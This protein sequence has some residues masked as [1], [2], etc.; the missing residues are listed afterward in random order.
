MGGPQAAEEQ[1]TATT[2]VGATLLHC[3][4]RARW[5]G[6]LELLKRASVKYGFELSLSTRNRQG[7]NVRVVRNVTLC[8]VR[9]YGVACTYVVQG[10]VVVPRPLPAHPPNQPANHSLPPGKSP[11]GWANLYA[12]PK[13]GLW[14]ITEGAL[15]R[16]DDFGWHNWAALEA[17]TDLVTRETERAAR[18][19]RSTLP[20]LYRASDAWR[21]GR[22]TH[23]RMVLAG[24]LGVP[25]G[26]E[27]KRLRFY[28]RWS[29]HDV[30]AYCADVPAFA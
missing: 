12:C 13:A 26:W 23:V 5:V 20:A 21:G 17:L 7:A 27:L 10:R 30:C 15:L 4:V 1:L 29:A 8:T 22:A 2:R 3:A 6:G 18:F 25:W 19:I 16:H 28:E 9:R 14:L 11:L 24:M